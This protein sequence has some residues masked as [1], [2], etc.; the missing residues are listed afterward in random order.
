MAG[1]EVFAVAF[2]IAVLG[3][4]V[5]IM[6][7]QRFKTYLLN[8]D[9]LFFHVPVSSGGD[10]EESAMVWYTFVVWMD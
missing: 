5:A 1:V 4:V 7:S 8:C 2:T 9:W 6:R 10:V 3:R